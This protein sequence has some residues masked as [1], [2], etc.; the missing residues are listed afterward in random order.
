MVQS[1]LGRTHSLEVRK[2]M[3]ESRMGANNPMFGKIV[4]DETRE[5]MSEAAKNRVKPNK[6]G[7]IV[8]VLEITLQRNTNQY[9]KQHEV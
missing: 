1:A 6:P 5:K 3:S 7:L 4:S 9:V 2:A 8:E